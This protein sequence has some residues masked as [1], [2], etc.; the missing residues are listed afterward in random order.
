MILYETKDVPSVHP[1]FFKGIH[2]FEKTFKKSMKRFYLSLL[3]LFSVTLAIEACHFPEEILEVDGIYYAFDGSWWVAGFSQGQDSIV[4]KNRVIINGEE[5]NIEEIYIYNGFMRGNQSSTSPKILV[6]PDGFKVIASLDLPRLEKLYLSKTI[7]R[8]HDICVC[9]YADMRCE[10]LKSIE[11]DKRNKHLKSIDGV[12]F[13]KN[14]EELFLY[15]RR[16][17]GE[18]Y[19][20]PKRV[21]HI[22]PG[23]FHECP[24]KTIYFPK[25]KK[26]MTAYYHNCFGYQ[27]GNQEEALNSMGFSDTKKIEFIGR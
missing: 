2:T 24:L 7:T 9:R 12:L 15:P 27:Y 10:N 23:A 19:E 11:V 20:I 18:S 13:S 6:V 3:C 26:E 21:K 8:T 22:L 17:Q 25:R 14:G 4:L 16:K 1:L 5:R